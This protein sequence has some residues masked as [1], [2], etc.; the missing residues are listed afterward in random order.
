MTQEQQQRDSERSKHNASDYTQDRKTVDG[1]ATG[2]FTSYSANSKLKKKVGKSPKNP[3]DDTKRARQ[4]AIFILIVLVIYLVYLVFS[5]QMSSFL[6]A[7]S[8][9]DSAWLLGACIAFVFYFIFGVLAYGIAVWLDHD[10]PVGIRDLMSVEASGIFFGN[11]TPLMAG[12]VPSQ[13]FRLTRTGLDAGL[14]SATQFTRFIVFHFGLVLFAAL[15]LLFKFSF[16]LNTYGDIVLINLIAFGMQVIQL[17]ILFVMCLCPRFVSKFG[18]LFIRFLSRRGWLKNKQKW[19]HLFNEQV[20]EFS[21]A[22]KSAAM[23]LPSMAL[24]L[25]V[26]MAQLACFYVIPWFLIHAFGGQADFLECLA[27]ASMVQM[28]ASAVP[29]PGGT[30]GA[31]GG[32]ALFFGP[33]FGAGTA[34]AGYLVWRLVTFIGP[35]ILSV[36]FLG[37]RSSHRMSIYRRYQRFKRR[38]S[39]KSGSSI[40]TKPRSHA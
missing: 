33:L 15:M 32:F 23:H 8:R 17:I 38:M 12:A 22:F 31:E 30:G 11:L 27:A 3:A 1:V 4:G 9:V 35:T 40:V 20:R 2:A 5:G 18:N 29:L 13:I 28:V 26:T 34:A 6:K 24:T 21:W 37:L 14:A 7:L 16:F 10:S 36:P 19:D 25:V 39:G